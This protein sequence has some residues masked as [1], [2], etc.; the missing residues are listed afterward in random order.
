LYACPAGA[1]AVRLQ[2]YFDASAGICGTNAAHAFPPHCTLTGF[3]RDQR[4][5]VGLYVKA[6]RTELEQSASSEGRISIRGASLQLMD[7]FHFILLSSVGIKPLVRRFAASAVSASRDGP[8]RT[9]EWLHLSLAYG[10]PAAHQGSL[11]AVARQR[12]G[13]VASIPARWE[14]CLYERTRDGRWI[15]HVAWPLT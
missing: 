11:R 6:L 2:E 1:L 10:F 5:S 12:L 15:R 14:V 8:L 7:G 3:F 13:S 4:S 9:K